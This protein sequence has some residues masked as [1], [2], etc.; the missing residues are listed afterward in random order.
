MVRYEGIQPDGTQPSYFLHIQSQQTQRCQACMDLFYNRNVL[1]M[2][3]PIFKAESC[4]HRSAF[5]E[6][7]YVFISVYVHVMYCIM[8]CVYVCEYVWLHRV[9]E[10]ACVCLWIE[11]KTLPISNPDSQ[12]KLLPNESQGMCCYVLSRVVTLLSFDVFQE[13]TTVCTPPS[14]DF[15]GGGCFG[16]FFLLTTRSH[17]QFTLTSSGGIQRAPV[18]IMDSKLISSVQ[19]IRSH[20]CLSFS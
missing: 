4:G 20:C 14:W 6:N 13:D 1:F 7:L 8:Y 17:T 2:H 3:L 12:R 18:S 5:K 10:Y 16:V 19:G 9:S 15:L 11:S